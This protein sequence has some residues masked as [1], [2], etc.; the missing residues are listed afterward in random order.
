MHWVEQWA[1]FTFWYISYM[2][3][4]SYIGSAQAKYIHPKLSF[5]EFQSK[6]CCSHQKNL[7]LVAIRVKETW[8]LNKE[9][10]QTKTE[11]KSGRRWIWDLSLPGQLNVL[12][13]LNN[14]WGVLLGLPFHFHGII[15]VPSLFSAYHCLAS[16][17]SPCAPLNSE[18]CSWH[19]ISEA[20]WNPVQD[21][22]EKDRKCSTWLL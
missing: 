15:S 2:W 20:S 9:E 1:I 14:V 8:T 11:M 16:S 19:K 4:N 13:E 12:R 17:Q 3:M 5:K 22:P 10:I 7:Q 18:S 6:C 21:L